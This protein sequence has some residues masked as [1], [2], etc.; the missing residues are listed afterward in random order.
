MSCILFCSPATCSSRDLYDLG[1]IIDGSRSA[2][3]NGFVQTKKFL[4]KLIDQFSVSSHKTH[5]GVILY[6]NKPQLMCGFTDKPFYDPLYLKLAILGMEFP[7]GEVR[8]DKALKM[9][10]EQLF[11]AGKD[12]ENIPDVLLVITKGRTGQ[13][14]EPYKDVLK[15]LKDRG[16][17]IIAVGIGDQISVDEL[18]E[19]ALGKS[20]NV[21]HVQTIDNLRP[22]KLSEKIHKIC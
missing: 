10:G 13:D 11:K 15:P 1:L 8:T 7:D 16:V 20:D 4:L 5:F 17:N 3:N 21:L 22:E 19:I 2:G 6:S 12:R 14:S 18:K 9:A